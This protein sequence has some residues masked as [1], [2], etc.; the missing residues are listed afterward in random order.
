MGVLLRGGRLKV[1]V[2]WYFFKTAC[3][4]FYPERLSLCFIDVLHFHSPC[5]VVNPSSVGYPC[6]LPLNFTLKNVWK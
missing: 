4:P 5:L 3:S 6:Y 2:K 1:V